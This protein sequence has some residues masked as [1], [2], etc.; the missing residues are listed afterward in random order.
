[1][2]QRIESAIWKTRKQKT[3]NQSNK[4]KK[5]LKNEDS[6]RDF[7][8]NIKCNSIHITVVSE[9]KKREQGIENLFEKIMTENFPNLVKAKKHKFRKHRECQTR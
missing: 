6:L 8:D 5:E 7:W 2:K 1:M 4:K 9:V 3:P